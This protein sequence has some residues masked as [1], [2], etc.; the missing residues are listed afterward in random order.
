[1]TSDFMIDIVYTYCFQVLIEGTVPYYPSCLQ[2]VSWFLL[3][4]TFAK[5]IGICFWTE[6]HV[7]EIRRIHE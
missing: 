2:C 7:L 6:S 1:M 5:S 4:V 3:H